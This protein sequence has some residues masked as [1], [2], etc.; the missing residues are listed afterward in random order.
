MRGALG[1]DVPH[2]AGFK[3]TK[4][5]AVRPCHACRG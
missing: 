5:A 3:T 2:Y 1:D 4:C